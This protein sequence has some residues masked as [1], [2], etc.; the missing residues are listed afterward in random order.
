MSQHPRPLPPSSNPLQYAQHLK[1]VVKYIS[2]L[3][4]GSARILGL[5]SKILNPMAFVP[6]LFSRS[7][8]PKILSNTLKPFLKP[9]LHPS[10]KSSLKSSLKALPQVHQAAPGVLRPSHPRHVMILP[11]LK[12]SP[13]HRRVCSGSKLLLS[14]TFLFGPCHHGFFSQY[15]VEELRGYGW[16]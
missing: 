15:D 11:T 7:S 2:D 8:T 10:L 5:F 14:V 6:Q 13:Y 3:S 12:P 4:L 16:R 9:S 1:Y